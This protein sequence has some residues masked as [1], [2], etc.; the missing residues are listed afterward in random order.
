[1]TRYLGLWFAFLGAPLAWSIQE[2]AGYAMMA[3]VCFPRSEAVVPADG[4]AVRGLAIALTLVCLI[5]ALWA[6]RSAARGVARTTPESRAGWEQAALA[7]DRTD[8]WRYLAFSGIIMGSVFS[9]LI[10]YNLL[11]LVLEPVCR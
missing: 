6:L 4:T 9:C 8:V 5:A 3:H 1:M 11:A 7:S 10:V 2:L